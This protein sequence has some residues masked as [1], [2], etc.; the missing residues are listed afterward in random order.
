MENKDIHTTE[1]IEE[2][3][4]NSLL[5]KVFEGEP[6]ASSQVWNSDLILKRGHRYLIEAAS[7]AG[8]SSLCAF[9]YGNR[10][11]YLGNIF[12][13][14]RNIK[15]LTIGEWQKLRRENIA[16]LPQELMLFPE[17]SA[18]DNIRLKNNITECVDE[19]RID[20][21]LSMMGLEERR[22]FPVGKMSVGQQQRVAIIRAIC[23]PFD[24]ILLDEPVSHLD[25]RNNRLAAGLIE[26]VARENGA[27]IISTSVGNPLLLSDAVTISL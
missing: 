10:K 27:A 26:D 21:W 11:D 14:N 23:Q 15:D 12:F 17:M 1:K 19:K 7:G 5:S 3:R 8:K 2:I 20:D 24:F 9:I 18:I 4:L 13:N 25:E 6:I 16:Y 22:D